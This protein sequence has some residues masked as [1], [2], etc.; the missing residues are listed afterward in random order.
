MVPLLPDFIEKAIVYPLSLILL[1]TER[2]MVG[3]VIIM[4]IGIFGAPLDDPNLGCVALCYSVLVLLEKIRKKTGIDL[5]YIVFD[6]SYKEEKFD[7]VCKTLEI[8][9]SRI[10]YCKRGNM[11][12]PVRMLKHMSGLFHMSKGLKKCDAVI[13]LTEGDSFSDIYGDVIFNGKTNVKLMIEKKGIPFFLGP[14]TIG[15]FYKTAN[16]KKAATAVKNAALVI[17]RDELSAQCVRELG[18]KDVEQ[19]IDLAF[20]LP[21]KA[22]HGES[23]K[24]KVGINVSSML[25]SEQNEMK[26]QR[27]SLKANYRECIDTVIER[28]GNRDD[29]EIYLIPHVSFDNIA[30]QKL[31]E[32]FPFVKCVEP[33]TNPVKVKSI[34]A[35]MDF[36][37]GARMHATIAAVSAGIPCIPM[38]YSRK[39]TGLFRSIG[40][41]YVVDLETSRTEDAIIAIMRMISKCDQLKKSIIGCTERINILSNKTE[42]VIE[43]EIRKIQ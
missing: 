25:Y 5:T 21:Y 14:Q 39:F 36:F 10:E 20:M 13:D 32:K 1:C 15:P 26:V 4:K 3:M 43:R 24:K 35:S 9:R 23:L 29:Y 31:K 33:Q 16:K 7:E 30:N 19:T 2:A 8:E 12:D 17:T 37:I 18:R 41:D 34:I 22:N 38:S 11:S 27:F 28:L 40:Y 42:K 6:Y